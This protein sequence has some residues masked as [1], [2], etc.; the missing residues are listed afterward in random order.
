M[1]KKHDAKSGGRVDQLVLK[2]GE[3]IA[4]VQQN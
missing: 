3:F 2:S 4:I 1:G